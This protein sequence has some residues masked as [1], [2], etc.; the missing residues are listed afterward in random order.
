MIT[1]KCSEKIYKGLPE[2]YAG[3]ESV[4]GKAYDEYPHLYNDT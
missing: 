2:R 3:G 1:N 4:T